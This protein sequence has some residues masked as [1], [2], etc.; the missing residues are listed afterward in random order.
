VTQTGDAIAVEILEP[1]LYYLRDG[2][3]KETGRITNDM[4]KKDSVK[5]I[6]DRRESAMP[7]YQY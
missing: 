5:E 6:H 7:G 2:E 4:G 1:V 3:K